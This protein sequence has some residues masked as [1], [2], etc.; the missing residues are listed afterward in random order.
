MNTF[1]PVASV[2]AMDLFGQL[3]S[4]SEI[5]VTEGIQY[6]CKEL[7]E[8]ST[9]GSLMK[10][11]ETLSLCAKNKHYLAF[12]PDSLTYLCRL[13]VP[14]KHLYNKDLDSVFI[15]EKT[16]LILPRLT[17]VPLLATSLVSDGVLP[18][19]LSIIIDGYTYEGK[20]QVY[21][22]CKKK[23]QLLD[24]PALAL[25]ILYS[26]C[27]HELC[28]EAILK[29]G[30]PAVLMQVLK[31]AAHQLFDGSNSGSISGSTS[32]SVSSTATA[33]ASSSGNVAEVTVTSPAAPSLMHSD[34]A[35]T[36]FGTNLSLNAKIALQTLFILSFIPFD[37]SE[38]FKNCPSACAVVL[39]SFGSD[40]AVASCTSSGRAVRTCKVAVTILMRFGVG[41][42]L[43]Y[44]DNLKVK[45][46]SFTDLRIEQGGRTQ[47]GS[48]LYSP[49]STYIPTLSKTPW[50]LL[51]ETSQVY[52]LFEIIR[53]KASS[54]GCPVI[55]S[56]PPHGP[57]KPIKPIKPTA[58]TTTTDTLVLEENEQLGMLDLGTV[59]Q[60]KITACAALHAVIITSGA[61]TSVSSDVRLAVVI[62]CA[63]E[64]LISHLEVLAPLS[65]E[66]ASLL[67]E[68]FSW[69]EVNFRFASKS[70]GD[71]VLGLLESPHVL[72]QRTALKML[73]DAVQHSPESKS[74]V[75]ARMPRHAIFAATRDCI[76]SCLLQLRRR[77]DPLYVV[78]DTTNE[79]R[80]SVSPVEMDAS[81]Q[82]LPTEKIT[83]LLLESLITATCYFDT[84]DQS[85]EAALSD[86]EVQALAVACGGLIEILESSSDS[87]ATSGSVALG[88][89]SR[90]LWTALLNLSSIKECVQVLLGTHLLKF[91][92]TCLKSRSAAAVADTAC[93]LSVSGTGH[94]SLSGASADGFFISS[95][96]LKILINI[97]SLFPDV[98]AEQLLNEG[99]FILLYSLVK[100]YE[101]NASNQRSSEAERQDGA[102]ASF[103]A[104]SIFCSSSCASLT[105][106]EALIDIKGFLSWCMSSITELCRQFSGSGQASSG[107][108][109]SKQWT[110]SS[111]VSVSVSGSEGASTEQSSDQTDS[112]S[113][114]VR[115]DI[116]NALEQ[117]I[118][119]IANLC[120]CSGGRSAV[121]TTDG[122]MTSLSVFISKH[123]TTDGD[124]V[125]LPGSVTYAAL[126]VLLAVAPLLHTLPPTSSSS[127]A[128]STIASWGGASSSSSTESNVGIILA[129]TLT[130]SAGSS[131]LSVI[132]KVSND[133]CHKLLAF[134]IEFTLIINVFLKVIVLVVLST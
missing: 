89:V 77:A 32:V 74:I 78:A 51:I 92:M 104:M 34:D 96:S 99:F 112:S 37:C 46:S 130:V 94:L 5:S 85:G 47:L 62:L 55:P 38:L 2:L 69:H 14:S 4:V 7:K 29:I 86:T 35:C 20:Q 28:R 66:A 119:L 13:L 16:L 63:D 8:P 91:L 3:S 58:T 25:K 133:Q 75:K 72:Q 30:V 10:A 61:S 45:S 118:A 1:G 56:I 59:L 113:E 127:S 132:D 23:S 71:T 73:F 57:I 21:P 67:S 117:R 53:Y 39:A 131:D 48:L 90:S 26:L 87:G 65:L 43:I 84:Q 6:V 18:G 12:F 134:I 100:R 54:S 22:I 114:V 121:L 124:T 60:A 110:A 109:E 107:I 126:S 36:L 11:V 24:L 64:D 33:S 15:I 40:A 111:S 101:E 115:G 44:S 88:A 81:L 83:Q 105:V 27:R 108:S 123:S 98:L 79:T 128:L 76:R 102:E 70:F 49:D 106:C 129:A 41:M 68:V 125:Q 31:T 97:S 52:L 82:L 19:L 122:F 116:K 120:R 80:A 95:S 42:P 50:Q 17:A 9:P 103:Q 93:Q